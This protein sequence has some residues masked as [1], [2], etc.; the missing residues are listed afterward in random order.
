MLL[1]ALTGLICIFTSCSAKTVKKNGGIVMDCSFTEATINLRE[2]TKDIDN[3]KKRFLLAGVKDPLVQLDT[4]SLQVHIE[5]PQITDKELYST[6]VTQ[7]GVFS[8]RMILNGEQVKD[9]YGLANKILVQRSL[10]SSSEV[11]V[12]S[13]PLR[14][15]I[16]VDYVMSNGQLGYVKNEHKLLMDTVFKQ[17]SDSLNID[18][19]WDFQWMKEDEAISTLYASS[20][21]SKRL[22]FDGMVEKTEVE[23]DERGHFEVRVE[24]MDEYNNKLEELTRVIVNTNFGFFIDDEVCFAGLVTEPLTEGWFS[25]VG[26]KREEVAQICAAIL[27]SGSLGHNLQVNAI[28]YISIQ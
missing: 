22:V 4:I 10:E 14:Q 20:K 18:F 19:H 2:A 28:E 6:L 3:I 1:V 9:I 26:G 7:K 12:D 21:K 25:L 24:L 15:Y 27:A 5:L 16:S 17:V 23:M 13:M 11:E 8:S